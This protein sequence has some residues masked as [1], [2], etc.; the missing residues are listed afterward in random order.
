MVTATASTKN[1]SSGT[2]TAYGLAAATALMLAPV[3]PAAA[4]NGDDPFSIPLASFDFNDPETG[5]SGAG[6]AAT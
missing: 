1:R 5:F 2:K 3:I 4:D 6:A